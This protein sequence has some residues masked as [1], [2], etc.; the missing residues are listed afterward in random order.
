MFVFTLLLGS[1]VA[2]PRVEQIERG[3]V[4][5]RPGPAE[6]A[7]AEPFRMEPATF[8][9]E[10]SPLMETERYKVSKLTFPSPIV[11]PD[12]ANNVVHA[13]YFQPTG[14]TGKR[15]ATIVLHILG[16]DFPLSRYYA[17][18]LADQ[19]VAALFV[20]LPY[21]GE[22]RAADGPGP[23]PKKFL[24][25]DIERTMRSTRQGVC[26]VRRGLRWLAQRP[27]VDPD[28]L[29]VTGISLG[30]VISSLVVSVDPDVRSGALLLAGGDLARI[31]WDMPEAAPFRQAWEADGK[32]FADLK[33]L[34]D[35]YDPL[36][37]A[38]GMKGKRVLM[39]DGKVDEVVPPESA[40]ALWEAGGRPTIVWYDCG[41]YSAAGFLLPAIRRAVDF[42]KDD[43]PR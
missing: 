17:A 37:H 42:L 27:E 23:V 26:D 19:G 7:V 12:P 24:S 31:L 14:F 16:A 35:P 10:L 32:T 9:Y 20:K 43:A 3:E 41:H 39:I 11:T 34:T 30:G 18:R 13:E 1:A 40:R 29:G 28:R 6:A 33:A 25:D 15:P 4:D 2:L 21:Y 38:A 5:V 22:R 8:A 36:T